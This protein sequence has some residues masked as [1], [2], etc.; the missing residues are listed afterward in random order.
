MGDEHTPV[1]QPITNHTYD[2]GKDP[3]CQCLRPLQY[4]AEIVIPNIIFERGYLLR[5][6]Q[7]PQRNDNRWG[8]E[9]HVFG[10]L[11]ICSSEEGTSRGSVVIKIASG[12]EVLTAATR[13]KNTDE[14]AITIGTP[15]AANWWDENGL[16]P[17]VELLIT[18][19]VPRCGQ[20]DVLDIKVANLDVSFSENLA[21]VA[22]QGTFIT[23]DY[24]RVYAPTRSGR[25]R[26]DP[27]I[28]Q[29]RQIFIR[30]SNG[31]VEG[32]F[33]LH[34]L[35][36]IKSRSGFIA[37]ELGLDSADSDSATQARV[38]VETGSGS[39][40]IKTPSIFYAKTKTKPN[41]APKFQPPA[42]DYVVEIATTYGKIEADIVVAS[43]ATIRSKAGDLLLR[44]LPVPFGAKG[45]GKTHLVTELDSGDTNII[46]LDPSQKMD[47]CAENT[48]STMGLEAR[49]TDCSYDPGLAGLHSTH[50]SAYGGIRVDYPESWTGKFIAESL[51][52]K[53]TVRGVNITIVRSSAGKPRVI[54]GHIGSG[55]SAILMKSSYGN[56]EFYADRRRQ[57]ASASTTKIPNEGD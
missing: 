56:I 1:E 23:T 45:N 55:G 40:T 50:Q 15:F 16:R 54:E 35:L 26:R 20:I 30:T 38:L 51:C 12:D 25:R 47:S 28:L 32:W 9:V 34:Q 49:R 22:T 57:D 29:S 8:R 13:C 33:P 2:V 5:I 39:I 31:N 21:L 52:G 19:Y 17:C 14:Q 4:E 27:Y 11:N 44:L 53:I 43:R 41:N 48:S 42:R 7:G 18:V 24:G 36:K 10:R 6:E 37:I 3:C 46:L